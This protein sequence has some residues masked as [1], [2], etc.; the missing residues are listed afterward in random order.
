M[1]DSSRMTDA[2]A[3][4]REGGHAIELYLSGFEALCDRELVRYNKGVTVAELL[5][6]V[7][8][9]RARRKAHPSTFE[10]A[11]ARGH[12]LILWNPWTAPDD[13]AE[14]V[15]NVRANGL[16]ELFTDLAKN[17]LRLYPDLPITYAAERDGAVADAWDDLDEGAARRKGYSVERPWRF[18][19]VRTR[20][21]HALVRDLRDHL[22][23]ETQLPQLAAVVA[24]I[25]DGWR[26]VVDADIPR[27]CEQV[28][29]EL[30]A[31]EA[32]LPPPPSGA[33]AQVVQFAGA[34]NNGCATC[35]NRDAWLDDDEPA[36]FARVD[37]ARATGRGPIVLA[38]REPTI[39][40]AF[41]RLVTRA[42]GDDDRL[43]GVVSNGRRFSYRA[44]THTSIA[45]GLRA[46]SIKL[47]A[48]AAASADAI[49]RVPGAHQQALDGIVELHRAGVH[50]IEL[51][52]PLHRDNVGAFA[53]FAELAGASQV[54]RIRIELG[55]DALGLTRLGDAAHA[56]ERLKTRGFELGL[57]VCATPA[58][59]GTRGFE[60][61]PEHGAGRTR[62]ASS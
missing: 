28:R 11:R 38:G 62:Y 27:I 40:P 19:D 6:A 46:A 29:V 32:A 61:L 16:G 25:G 5:S 53:S 52:A 21:A 59:A 49:A 22:G 60:T 55:L 56:V 35:S 51:R 10:Y 34:C 14:T 41:T 58:S 57:H 4:A 31:L 30:R 13:L 48:P 1:R 3:A 37:A 15:H 54:D 7:S 36:L 17:R 18:L 42:R 43:V 8:A 39:H 26:D 47:F 20:L 24:E 50:A 23:P 12:S 45:A 2:I 44:F 9:M 33:R